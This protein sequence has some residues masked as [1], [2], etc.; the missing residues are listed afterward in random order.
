MYDHEN[1]KKEIIVLSSSHE[2]RRNIKCILQTKRSK[3]EKATI[4]SI[5][6]KSKLWRQKKDQ[7]L[8]GLGRKNNK[9][10]RAEDF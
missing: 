7:W 4:Q 6:K 5:L 1:L 2:K 3:S 9:L 10:C 8:P